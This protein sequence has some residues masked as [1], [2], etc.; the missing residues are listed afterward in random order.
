MGNISERTEQVRELRLQIV[1]VEGALR[2]VL[3]A[4]E[5]L[6][7]ADTLHDLIGRVVL[8]RQRVEQQIADPVRQ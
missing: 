3:A 5:V 6:G 7:A 8:L 1:E 4:A 2:R